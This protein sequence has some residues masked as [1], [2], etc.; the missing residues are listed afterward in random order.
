ML[1]DNVYLPAQFYEGISPRHILFFTLHRLRVN[2]L[3]RE[4]NFTFEIL[5]QLDIS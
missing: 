2:E 1:S 4:G 5:S 3:A